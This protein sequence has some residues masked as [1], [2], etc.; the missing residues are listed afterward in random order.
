MSVATKSLE[1]MRFKDLIRSRCG[2]RL[3]GL[4]EDTLIAAVAKRMAAN[5]I[6]DPGAYLALVDGQE[7]EFEEFVALMTIN[8]TYFYR[9][10]EQLKLLVDRLMPR[11]MAAEKARLPIRILSAGCSTG[12]EPYSIA[13]AVLER[14]GEA[15]EN[16]VRIVG[17]DIDRYALAKARTAQYNKFSFRS[18]P[19]RL[20]E[21][22]FR[23]LEGGQFDLSPRVAGMVRFFPLNLLADEFPAEFGD[24]DIVFFRNVS[25][26]FDALGRRTIQ[27]HLYDAMTP[28]GLLLIG[29]AETIANDFGIFRQ[30]EIDGL[31]YFAKAAAGAEMEAPPPAPQAVPPTAKTLPTEATPPTPPVPPP[32]APVPPARHEPQDVIADV[33]AWIRDK[34]YAKASGILASVNRQAPADAR[35]LALEGYIRMT[36]RDFAGAGALAKAALDVDEW[37]QDALV[38]SGL[39]AKWQGRNAEAVACFQRAIYNKF[40]CW[41]AYYYLGEL[42]RTGAGAGE[43]RRLYRVA[44]QL[45]ETKSDPDGGLVLPLDLPLADVRFLCA[46]HAVSVTAAER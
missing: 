2:L 32:A 36:N 37:A 5:G 3:E 20:R 22:Y 35:L 40:D 26:Y 41:P 43:W 29:M 6:D 23:P 9:E 25:I 12:E 38:L 28:R 17:G 24:F 4:G 15:A 33:R 42:Y 21:R 7:D 27:R 31:F 11:L 16:L 1:L 46:H 45:L 13:I 39:V 8:E 10:P 19:A 34:Q 44:L 14:F 30:V 18:M